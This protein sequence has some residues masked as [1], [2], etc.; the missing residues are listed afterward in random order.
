[1][2]MPSSS[3]TIIRRVLVGCRAWRR[4]RSLEAAARLRRPPE[5]EAAALTRTAG[6]GAACIHQDGPGRGLSITL[7]EPRR[8]SRGQVAGAVRAEERGRAG[9]RTFARQMGPGPRAAA[10]TSPVG[11]GAMAGG[12]GEAAPPR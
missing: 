4:P 8:R 6:P 1:M 5:R 10:V 11:A 7:L 2:R 9:T 3:P 12:A